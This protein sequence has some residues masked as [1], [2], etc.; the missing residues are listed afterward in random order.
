M[1]QTIPLPPQDDRFVICACLARVGA[2]A[3]AN[4]L[5]FVEVQP[6][7]HLQNPA[8]H[9]PR[10]ELQKYISKRR[11]PSLRANVQGMQ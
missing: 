11:S 9:S 7:S 8:V 4:T 3:K 10:S 1:V 5:Q 6:G 2:G